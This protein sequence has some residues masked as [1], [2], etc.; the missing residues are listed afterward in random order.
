MDIDINNIPTPIIDIKTIAY[1]QAIPDIKGR[2]HYKTK[3]NVWKLLRNK[4]DKIQ[5]HWGKRL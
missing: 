4:N 5:M 3:E 1:K 2:L